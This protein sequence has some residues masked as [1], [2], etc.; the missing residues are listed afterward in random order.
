MEYTLGTSGA[1]GARVVEHIRLSRARPVRPPE[2]LGKPDDQLVARRPRRIGASVVRTIGSV[3]ALIPL[4]SR[5]FPPRIPLSAARESRSSC[6]TIRSCPGMSGLRT[7]D[8]PSWRG[9]SGS[10]R[11]AG[12]HRGERVGLA[13]SCGFRGLCG[14][15]AVPFLS[16]RLGLGAVDGLGHAAAGASIDRSAPI[17]RSSITCLSE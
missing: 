10:V 1:Q 7:A 9:M 12:L 17:P 8:P 16:H 11:R 13:F 14:L 4:C 5:G 15:F 2:A 3:S 6:N